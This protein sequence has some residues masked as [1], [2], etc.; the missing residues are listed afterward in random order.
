MHSH[1]EE[2]PRSRSRSRG[3]AFTTM[4]KGSIVPDMERLHLVAKAPPVVPKRRPMA[5]HREIRQPRTGAFSKARVLWDEA[6]RKTF[7]ERWGAPPW[8]VGCK[9]PATSPPS[10]LLPADSQAAKPQF[11][12]TP[13]L[14]TLPL[15]TLSA[16][17]LGLIKA[18]CKLPLPIDP[19][20]STSTE[21]R[22]RTAASSTRH[23]MDRHLCGLESCAALEEPAIHRTQQRHPR[24]HGGGAAGYTSSSIQETL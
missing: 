8:V 20:G 5:T 13:E 14:S 6:L 9:E 2:V 23:T 22:S 24:H 17:E 1:D 3:V 7:V 16:Y 4:S 21:F 18:L 11:E 10:R 19:R 12:T 15:A